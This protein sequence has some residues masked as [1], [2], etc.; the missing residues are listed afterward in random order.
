MMRI[1][2]VIPLLLVWMISPASAQDTETAPVRSPSATPMPIPDDDDGPDADA[3]K[4]KAQAQKPAEKTA[5]PAAKS[6]VQL[7]DNPPPRYTVK[8][9]DTLWGISGR[10]LKNPWKWP[11]VWGM[12]KDE[13]K[14]PHL[15]Y[16]GDV[17][18]LDLSGATARLRL[19]GVSDGGLSRWYGYQLQVS[20]MEPR[21]RSKM[22]GRMGIPAIPAKEIGPFLNRPLVID[23]DSVARSPQIVATTQ[24]R[25]VLS[26]PD[27]AYATG[28]DEKQGNYW[29][30][31]RPG[32][33]FRDPESGEILG[34]EAVY[35]GDAQVES[36]GEVST[37]RIVQ[38]IQEVGNGDRLTVM[39][40]VQSLPYIPRAPERNI[41]G[42]VM[43]GTGTSVSEIAPLSVI[44]LNRGKR[45][46]VEMGHVLGLYRSEGAVTVGDRRVP[47]PELEYGI[48]FV[49]R[50][51][52]KMSYALVMQSKQQ[53]NLNDV[54]KNP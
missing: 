15:I 22:L 50:V 27:I 23:P 2:S 7:Q 42:K 11:E 31:Y 30:L 32:R 52:D 12:N 9:G 26:A 29:N 24:D 35:L 18:I 14:N 5:P 34:Y 39:P 3:P 54:V 44:V 17:I 4:E 43:A 46:G 36:F 8:R 16:P 45:D 47:L 28:L 1:I 37:V 19:E 38:A 33:T 53:V 21:M 49:F 20:K 10:F 41:R 6:D 13:V 51:F 48:V 25:V 40:P